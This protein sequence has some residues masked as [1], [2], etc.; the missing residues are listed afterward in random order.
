MSD[1]CPIAPP[2]SN[3]N[4]LV[5]CHLYH[6]DPLLCSGGSPKIPGH[7]VHDNTHCQGEISGTREVGA[8][9]IFGFGNVFPKP[10]KSPPPSGVDRIFR[11]HL[12][13]LWPE[14]SQIIAGK[15]YLLGGCR[16][17]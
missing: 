1:R 2:L 8:G 11:G 13:E 14:L 4:A 6:Q 15:V 10:L 3:Q 9:N 17:D 12:V 7:H 5:P 16:D